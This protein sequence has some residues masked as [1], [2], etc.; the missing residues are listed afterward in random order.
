MDCRKWIFLTIGVSLACGGCLT[1]QQETIP[2]KKQSSN[3]TFPTTLLKKKEE[4]RQPQVDTC[5]K[6]GAFLEKQAF[7]EEM[8]PRGREL[9]LE[10]A[11]KAY[12]QALALEPNNAKALG[13]IARVYTHLKDYKR[14]MEYYRRATKLHPNDSDLW[15]DLG[16]CHLRQKQYPQGIAALRKSVATAPENRDGMTTLGY[17]LA[18]AGQTR[19]AIDVLSKVHGPAQAHYKVGRMLLHLNQKAVAKQHFEESLRLDPNSQLTR[20]ALAGLN[21]GSSSGNHKIANISFETE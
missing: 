4:K 3:F 14:A 15:L 17:A 13:G 12:V 2:E 21:G 11:R 19:E 5:L 18:R 9:M 8:T 7:G 10:R 16:M 6:G 20:H 1:Q